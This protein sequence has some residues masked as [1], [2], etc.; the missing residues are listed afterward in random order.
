MPTIA[1]FDGIKIRIYYHDHPPLHFHVEYG[2][3][4][5]EIAIATLELLAGTLP[6]V[7]YRKIRAWAEP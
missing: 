5:A 1:E 7:V 6:G 3:G 2:G 4:E